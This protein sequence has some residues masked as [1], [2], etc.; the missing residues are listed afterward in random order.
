VRR[1]VDVLRQVGDN[2]LRHEYAL[3]LSDRTGVDTYE[4]ARS[5]EGTDRTVR[6]RP[7]GPAAQG[8]VALSGSQRIEREALRALLTF[9]ELLKDDLLAPSEND[10]TLPLHKS[11]FRLA[12]AELAEQGNVDVGRIASRVQD[13]DLQRIAS[14]LSVGEAPEGRVA[15]DTLS[16]LRESALE[17]HIVER[18][19]RLRAL[20]PNR[21]ATAYDALF[22][23]LLGLE[24][25]KR[26]L[27]Q[28]G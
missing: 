17:R 14:E 16:R 23:E 5:L 12:S 28:L 26:A 13:P 25:Q 18:K 24:K 6:R 19:S 22:E 3:W 2:L 20:D 7:S 10:F 8:P 1:G 21:E 27:T 15:R 4:I 9:P 11:L